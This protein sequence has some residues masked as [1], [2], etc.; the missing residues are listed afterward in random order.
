M[1]VVG[2]WLTAGQVRSG[3]EGRTLLW[4]TVEGLFFWGV[5]IGAFRQAPRSPAA[6]PFLLQCAGWTTYFGLATLVPSDGPPSAAL[7]GVFGP[8]SYLHAPS[9][10]HLALAL[11]WPQ[12]EPRWKG[13]V[14]GWYVLHGVLFIGA[15][16]MLLAGQQDGFAFIDGVMRR[17]ALNFLALAL[18]IG[19]LVWARVFL[20]ASRNRRRTLDLGAG[21]ILL[22]MG[23]G[24]LGSVIPLFATQMEP[25]LPLSTMLFAILPAGFALAMLRTRLFNDRRLERESSD[26]Q[27][28]LLLDHDLTA[29][30]ADLA[31]HLRV[32]F[33]AQGAMIRVADGGAPRRLAVAGE[34]FEEWDAA[35]LTDEVQLTHAP[36]AIGYPLADEHGLVG[37][38]RIGGSLAGGFGGRE[39][40]SLQRLARP[41]T[42]VLRTKLA[43]QELRRTAAE[44]ARLAF[45]F[46]GAG[47]LLEETA[48]S[49]SIGAKET[50]DGARQQAT[51]LAEVQ[52]V[53]QGAAT[54]ATEVRAEATR[55]AEVGLAVEEQ[56][57]ALVRTSELLAQEI[58]SGMQ[59]LVLVR[60][61]VDA[62]VAR[63]D[64]IQRISAAITGFA[65]Q[66]NLLAL[67][68]AIEA[69]RAGAEGQG[70]AVVAE[71]VRALA[72]SSGHSARDI[73]RLVAGI[74][75]EIERAVV[76]LARVLED[77]KGA[78]ARGRSGVGLFEAAH[79]RIDSLIQA[80]S[81]LKDRADRLQA[82][83]ATIEAAVLRSTQV[84]KAQLTRAEGAAS[85]V[86]RQLAT[87][88]ELRANADRLAQVGQRLGGL[89]NL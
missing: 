10:V 23:P 19:A 5:G 57:E 3:A 43:D 9:L 82:A 27:I 39:L 52:S 83:T 49:S 61:E 13:V 17:L 54:V 41:L 20:A 32:T 68:A 51:D 8:G 35:P 50:A 79:Q 44:L 59:T 15:L 14:L 21:A 55:S 4:L 6:L 25:G 81:S 71:E 34:P 18:S 76:A 86:E 12:E 2:L 28:R 37:E 70:F 26:L 64:E 38:I 74:R 77:M 1:F 65:F 72:E 78:A 33:E 87:A 22:G 56:G 36:S 60:S 42:A 47:A 84:A 67:N 30:S 7:F 69:A 53:A 16:A 80:A 11:A 45:S 48:R 73:S 75:E 58:E 62:L 46:A 66:T 40:T 24:W 31:Q 88:S 89:L 29:A 85:A 63:G